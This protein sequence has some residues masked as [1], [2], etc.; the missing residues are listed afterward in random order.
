[1]RIYA[2]LEQVTSFSYLGHIITDDGRSEAEI[3]KRIAMAKN[4]FNS[5]KSV[6]TSREINN[7]L[8][9]R[10][11]KCYVYSTLLYGAEAWT[12]NKQLESRIEALEM[13][14]CLIT[15]SCHGTC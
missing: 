4:A 3:K 13:W 6:L 1:M 8:K 10:I 15:W 5:M 9:M 2:K 12:L 7:A 11:V 14:K